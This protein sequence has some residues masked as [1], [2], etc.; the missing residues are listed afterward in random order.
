M[1]DLKNLSLLSTLS[2]TWLSPESSSPPFKAP[3]AY[4]PNI[5]SFPFLLAYF[6]FISISITLL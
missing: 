2:I 3:F 1:F 5:S 4:F 6:F